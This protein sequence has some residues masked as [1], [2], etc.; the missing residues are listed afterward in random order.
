MD[1]NIQHIIELLQEAEELLDE[2]EESEDFTSMT[3]EVA[4]NIVSANAAVKTCIEILSG[5]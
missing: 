2:L 5:E 3:L 1:R 4:E